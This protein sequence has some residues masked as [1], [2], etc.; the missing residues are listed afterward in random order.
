MV[1]SAEGQIGKVRLYLTKNALF[2][3]RGKISPQKSSL[4]A[5]LLQ[6]FMTWATPVPFFCIFKDHRENRTA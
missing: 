5:F 2:R 3:T 6:E 1:I 4:L